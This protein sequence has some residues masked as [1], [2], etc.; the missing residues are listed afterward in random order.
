MHFRIS[1]QDWELEEVTCF[2]EHIPSLKVQEG[3]DSLA[4]K[5]DG[6]GK[7]SVKSYYKSLRAETNLLFPA[8]EI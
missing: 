8:K 4:W 6:R 3:E 2:L 7:F 5:N 1:F